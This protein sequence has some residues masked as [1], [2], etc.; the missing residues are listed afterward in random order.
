MFARRTTVLASLGLMALP[1]IASETAPHGSY[2]G[3][4]GP[5]HWGGTCAKGKAQSPIDVPSAAAKAEKLPALSFD[6]RPG[7]LRIIDNGHS[8][9]VD[10]EPGSSLT[11]G[12]E[13]YDLVQFHFHKP[14]EEAID[15]RHYA[16]VAHL[17]HRN[18]KG[19]LAVVAVLLK[20]GADNPLIDQLWRNL[21]RE[22]Q[23]EETFHGVLI[24]PAQLLPANR[25]YFTY[26]GSLTTPP[27]TEGVRWFVLETPVTIGLKQ[28]LT[29]GKLY[30]M[31]ARP[32]QPLN[33][34]QVLASK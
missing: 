5:S 26:Q 19:D 11:V 9:Q 3:A 27:C 21:P 14:S 7:P 12:G 28:I 15:G 4:E 18:A 29:F 33:K 31:N 6:Y 20:A 10:A 23:H 13:R 25:A 1:A 2:S 30:Q 22:K 32:V 17:V 34:R 16:M 24:S 8:V